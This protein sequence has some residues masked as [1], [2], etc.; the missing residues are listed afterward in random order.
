MLPLATVHKLMRESFQNSDAIESSII[1]LPYGSRKPWFEKLRDRI[2]K[3]ERLSTRTWAIDKDDDMI[4]GIYVTGLG[5]GRNRS[6]YFQMRVKNVDG[7][8]GVWIYPANR[9]RGK[10]AIIPSPITD[11]ADVEHFI[12]VVK[13]TQER[14][15]L[16]DKQKQKVASLQQ[17]GLTARL[18]ELSAEHQFSFAISETIREVRLSIRIRQRK[19]AYHF[20]FPK[21]KL[22]Q[23]IEQIPDLVQTLEGLQSLGVH[24]RT[25]NRFW[26][27]S[28]S[29]W[30][31]PPK[32][33]VESKPKMA[34][35]K[36]RVK[37]KR[38]TNTK[39]SIKK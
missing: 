21:S 16:K 3:L 6:D 34:A 14:A 32:V 7:V 9:R 38:P 35:T 25:E 22:G 27:R 10:T 23:V 37:R 39:T 1:S 4:L 12:D 24:F 28:E 29:E 2:G 15:H 5:S 36:K 18:K 17:T 13:A 19:R 31:N 26:R 33:E 8:E 20:S 11:T 30:V